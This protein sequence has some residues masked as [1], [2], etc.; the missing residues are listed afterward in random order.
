EPY[1]ITVVITDIGGAKT[2]VNSSATVSGIVIPLAGAL[3]PAS[4][5]GAAN[6]DAIT[7]DNQPNFFGTTLPGTVV[8]LFATPTTGG[9]AQ[10]IGLT[11]ANGA[12][13][14]S[15]NSFLLGD[16]SYVI[17]ATASDSHG[18]TPNTIT[19]EPSTHPLVIDTVGPRVT[20]VSF[21]RLHGTIDVTFQ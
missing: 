13:F 16:G 2:V 10:L 20:A 14:W 9:T 19:I 21:D 8:K 17:T 5:H 12:G 4:D 1:P 18:N 6:F 7:N 3:N 11:S 15:I